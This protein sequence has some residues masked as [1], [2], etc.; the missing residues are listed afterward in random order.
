MATLIVL[1]WYIYQV[2]KQSH[3]RKSK[4]P[5]QHAGA[6]LYKSHQYSDAY[7]VSPSIKKAY[8]VQ[9]QSSAS[10]HRAPCPSSYVGMPLQHASGFRQRFHICSNPLVRWSCHILSGMSRDSLM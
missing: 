7:L 9:C 5:I 8:S 10:E 1:E 4:R 6:A 2:L 3:D